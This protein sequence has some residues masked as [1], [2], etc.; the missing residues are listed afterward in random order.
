MVSGP[1]IV[2]RRPGILFRR[3]LSEFRLQPAKLWLLARTAKATF[4]VGLRHTRLQFAELRYLQ[5]VHW[6]IAGDPGGRRNNNQEHGLN[7]SG[8]GS[9][10][11]PLPDAQRRASY[12]FTVCR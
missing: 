12:D 2:T 9:T 6:R 10:R 8:L 3:Q 7:Q 1:P 4:L 11:Q 5:R